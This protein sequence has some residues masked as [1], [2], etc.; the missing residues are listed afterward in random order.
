MG[1]CHSFMVGLST[2]FEFF[3]NHSEVCF[4]S[5]PK[6][7]QV[8]KM[9]YHTIYVQVALFCGQGQLSKGHNIHV[10]AAQGLLI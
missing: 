9:N 3:W 6:S 7:S 10:P 2:S 4:H 8:D 1:W 5:D